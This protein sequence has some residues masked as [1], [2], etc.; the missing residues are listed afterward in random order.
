MTEENKTQQE[1]APLQ[2]QDLVTT[3]EAIQ[4]AASRG[5]FRV[6][7]FS[8]IGATYT[9]LYNFLV[10]SGVITPTQPTADGNA[11]S[12]AEPKGN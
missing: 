9:R 1:V 3:L 4:L 2:S 8:A 12:S 11:D 6:E 5:A 10:N 7:E